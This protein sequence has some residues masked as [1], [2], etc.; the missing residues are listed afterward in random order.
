[1]EW[2]SLEVLVTDGGEVSPKKIAEAADRHP[3]SVRRALNQISELVDREYGSVSLRSNDVAE[4]VYEAVKR[5]KEVNRRAVEAGA[6]ALA[7]ADRGIDENTSAFIAW[8]ASHGVT[9]SERTDALQLDLG[10][11][12]AKNHDPEVRRILR[13]GKRLWEGAKRDPTIFRSGRDCYGF[14]N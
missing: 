3:D 6:K 8:A 2:D 11:V 12:D 4:L 10:E 9:V 5:A 7:A 1:M 14:G 13:E